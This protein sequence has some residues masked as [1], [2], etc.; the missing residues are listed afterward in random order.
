[1]VGDSTWDCEAAERA[2]L[3]AVAVLT[4]GFSE[5]SCARPG[6]AC[7]FESLRG[8]CA[9]GSESTPLA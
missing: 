6:A 1:M 2:G 4:G 9:T 5:A 7:V 8:A 3:P